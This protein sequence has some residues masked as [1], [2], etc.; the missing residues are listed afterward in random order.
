MLFLG[1]EVESEISNQLVGLMM[2]LSIEDENKDLYFVI[3]SPG[4]WVLPGI[5]I[6]DNIQFVPSEL[7]TICLGLAVS[8]GSFILV[9]V[10]RV[11]VVINLI[12]VPFSI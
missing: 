7:C 11:K 1:Q 12:V 2:Y 3:N 8:M 6:Y 10:I 4:G 5:A 9:G